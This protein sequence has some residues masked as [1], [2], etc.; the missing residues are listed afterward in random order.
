MRYKYIHIFAASF[1]VAG[2]SVQFVMS[3]NQARHHVQET[4]D[5]KNQIAHEK[6]LFELYDAY[7]V[8][9]QL[10]QSVAENLS[11][12]DNMMKET[13]NLLKRYPGFFCMHVDFTEDYY[14][15]KGKWYSMFSYRLNDSISTMNTDG[16]QFDYSQREWY[17]GALNSGDKGYWGKAYWSDVINNTLFTYSDD[18]VDSQGNPVCVVGVD[19]SISWLQQLLEQFK[20]IDEAVCMI[21][22]SDGT[23][24]TASEN[25]AGSDPLDLSEDKWILS[26]QTFEEI[27]MEMVI[28]VP[29][30]LIWKDILWI[31]LWPLVVFVLGSVIVGILIRRML[32][33]QQEKA[34]LETEKKVISHELQIAHDIQMGILRNDFPHDEDIVVHADL[35]PML[36]V[37]GDLYDFSRQGDVLWF[38]IGDVSGKGVPATMFMSATINL[39]RSAL[40]H[41]TSPKAIVEEMNAVLSDNNPSLTFVTAFIGRLHIPS[42]Q[43]TY[44]N[45]AHMPPLVLNPDRSV[46]CIKMI[47][48]LPLGFDEKYKFVEEGCLLGKDEKL[49]LYTDGVTESRDATWKMMGGEKWREIVRHDD[50]LL[51]AVRQYIG[52][53]EQTDDITLMTIC[54]RSEVQPVSLHVPNHIDQWPLLRRTLHE[55]GVCIGIEKSALKKLEVALEEAVVNIVN[56]SQATEIGL[57]VQRDAPRPASPLDPSRNGRQ[58]VVSIT[59]TDNGVPFD[60][61]S[62]ET[63]PAKAIDELQIGGMGISLLRRIVDELHYERTNEWNQ[64]TII[65]Y[66]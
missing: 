11:Q 46:R 53:A 2:M 64:L 65:K 32:R 10:K 61:T 45:A 49:V 56:Y 30:Q 54:K 27:D 63:D 21:Y 33:D 14:P 28:A 4:I 3:Y 51:G 55:Y 57:I 59:L 47:P 26:R 35:L 62:V 36:E 60:P 58:S 6:I 17:E 50:D 25:Q 34:Q 43:L 18:I 44:C 12:P 38:I 16:N 23:V 22:S 39:F 37:G 13:G 19:F 42:G 20:P 1:L 52:E 41:Q 40:G 66:L 29:K 31:I 24:L 9:D 5:L 15:E 7:E 48:N 8:I